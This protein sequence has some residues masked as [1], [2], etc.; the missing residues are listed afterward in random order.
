MPPP[1]WRPMD[2]IPMIGWSRNR[3][4]GQVT[5]VAGSTRPGRPL[6]RPGLFL[7]IS[8]DKRGNEVADE[9]DQTM[10][11]TSKL[12]SQQTLTTNTLERQQF[13]LS[14]TYRVM[15]VL[16]HERSK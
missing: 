14:V 6:R 7:A 1:S 15:S 4:R 11:V 2:Q 16:A 12:T 3:Y 13:S 8:D 10:A 5:A 9:R